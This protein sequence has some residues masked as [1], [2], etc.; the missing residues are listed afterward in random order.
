M[1]LFM[2]SKFVGT[3]V[4]KEQSLKKTGIGYHADY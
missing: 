3:T 4:T 2:G 1:H